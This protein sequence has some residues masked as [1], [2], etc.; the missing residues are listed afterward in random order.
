ML[1]QRNILCDYFVYLFV[2]TKCKKKKMF[3][4]KS[5]LHKQWIYGQSDR[6]PP[7]KMNKF[8]R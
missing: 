3:V 5:Y 1:L 4:R 6:L 2:K 8:Y 7:D